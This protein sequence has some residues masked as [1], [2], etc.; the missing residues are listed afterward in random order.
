MFQPGKQSADVESGGERPQGKRG[1]TLKL[2]LFGITK[3]NCR[4]SVQKGFFVFGCNQVTVRGSERLCPLY[5]KFVPKPRHGMSVFPPRQNEGVRQV[6]A[7]QKEVSGNVRMFAAAQ[8]EVARLKAS[9]QVRAELVTL[10]SM[11]IC[12]AKYVLEWSSGPASFYCAPNPGPMFQVCL[13]DP[14]SLQAL[15]YL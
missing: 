7:L 14:F 5:Q 3:K 1:F 11:E 15:Y 8:A 6:A 4:N 9:L 2:K 13:L 12:S 10:V